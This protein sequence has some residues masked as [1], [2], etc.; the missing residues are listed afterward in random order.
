[1]LDK[2]ILVGR[3]LVMCTKDILPEIITF[4]QWK[5]V[6]MKDNK[7]RMKIVQEEQ[8][9]LVMKNCEQMQKLTEIVYISHRSYERRENRPN[10]RCKFCKIR[11]QCPAFK[12]KCFHCDIIGHYKEVCEHKMR[13]E[14][15]QAK[16]PTRRF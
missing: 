9:Q 16:P 13:K 5:I 4:S 8:N 7:E 14:G 6:T 12:V 10:Q 1:M 2:I 3:S 15:A 11:K